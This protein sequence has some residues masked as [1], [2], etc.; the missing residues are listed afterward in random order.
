MQVFMCLWLLIMHS[1]REVLSSSGLGVPPSCSWRAL[2]ELA[3][4]C[5]NYVGN[6]QDVLQHHKQS[7]SLL[8]RTVLAISTQQLSPSHDGHRENCTHSLEYALKYISTGSKG[9]QSPITSQA[10]AMP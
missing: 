2:V 7:T 3:Q 6:V 10:V 4:N 5:R 9:D 8:F 1:R